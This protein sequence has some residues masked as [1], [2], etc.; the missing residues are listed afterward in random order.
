M[1]LSIYHSG[2]LKIVVLQR[3][4][5]LI[6]KFERS[7]SDCKLHNAAVIRSWGTTRGLGELALEGPKESTKIDPCHGLVEF[8]ILTMVLSISAKEDRWAGKL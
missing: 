7:G 4:W 5:V 2:D 8:D 6:G 1:G 3:G